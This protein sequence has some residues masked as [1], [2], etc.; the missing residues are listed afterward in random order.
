MKVLLLKDVKGQGKAGEI[1]NVSNGYANNFLLPRKLAT[2]AEGDALNEAKQKK[3]A[4]ELRKQKAIAKAK[5]D[6]ISLSTE[7]VH[8]K[9]KAGQKEGKIFG[10]VTAK[11]I[12]TELNNMGYN[13]DKRDVLLKDPIR[14]LGRLMVEVKLYTGIIVRVNVVVEAL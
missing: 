1:I 12:A 10:S 14:S 2:S 8:I 7:T 3:A 9:V 6:Q 11:E 4:E 13:I 5:E